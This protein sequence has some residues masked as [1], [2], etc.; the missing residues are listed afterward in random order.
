M[1]EGFHC[2]FRIADCISAAPAALDR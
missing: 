2:G 1:E